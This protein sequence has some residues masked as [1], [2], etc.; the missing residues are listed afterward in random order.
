MI[1]FIHLIGAQGNPVIDQNESIPAL[2][3]LNFYLYLEYGV[4]LCGLSFFT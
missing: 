4:K 2:S 1:Y 3:L